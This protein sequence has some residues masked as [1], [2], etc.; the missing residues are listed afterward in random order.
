MK[1]LFGAWSRLRKDHP[2][3]RVLVAARQLDPRLRQVCAAIG[4]DVELLHDPAGK[5]AARFNANW[6][7]RAY[8]LDPDGRVE[9]VQGETTPD[10]EAMLQVARLWQ[11]AEAAP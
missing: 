7:A 3:A 9:Y 6:P 1:A 4:A 10:T 11:K 8:S 5:T 2:E